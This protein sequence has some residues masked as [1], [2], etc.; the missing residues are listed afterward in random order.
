MNSRQSFYKRH[1]E[2]ILGAISILLFLGLWQIVWDLK[3]ISALFFTGPSEV[4]MK[5]RELLVDGTLLSDMAFSGQ[6]FAIGFLI[7][8]VTGIV[9]GIIFGWY[10]WLRLLTNPIVTVFYSMPRVAM[11][12]L[13][14]MW[15]GTGM[16]SKIYIVFLFSFFPILVNTIAGV[17]ALDQ[18]LLRAARAYCATDWQIFKTVALPGSVPF[19]LTGIRQGVSLGLIG[20]VIGEIMGGGSQ[21]I[22]YMVAYG[23]SAFQTDLMFVGVVIIAFAGILLT[24][25][26]ERL[27]RHF[28]RW[29][30]EH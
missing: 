19:I 7:S 29:K 10:R 24:W 9:L 27:E 4:A 30:P 22:G 6:T 17:K 21:G 1:D 2:L 12:P 25:V 5:F 23:G 14:I 3:L 11:V 20:V 16:K 15:V 18:D 13:I 28:S 26:A 8:S